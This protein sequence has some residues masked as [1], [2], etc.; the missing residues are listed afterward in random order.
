MGIA[1]CAAIAAEAVA[2]ASGGDSYLAVIV[3]AL[4]AIV[5]GGLNTYKKGWIAL[6]NRNLN[7]NALMSIAVTGALLIGQ[8]LE[9]AMVMVLFALA[10]LIE[11]LSLD[12]ARN[13]IRGVMAMA[14]DKATVQQAEGNWAE[15]D[16]RQ[17]IVGSRIRVRPGE[18]I[19]LE[20][21]LLNGQSSVNQAPITGESI[22][23]VKTIGDPVFAGTINETGSFEYRVT[24]EATHST[25]A[26]II[27]AVEEAQG[28][29]TPT[30][31]FVDQFAKVYTPVVFELA[32]LVAVV[33]PLMLGQ[34]WLDWIYKALVLL[35][36][37][38]PC[39]LVIPPP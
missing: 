34:A 1:G 12:R 19:P 24:A 4:I 29:R 26:R 28:S 36:I 17:V 21:E 13:A 9:A 32:L 25:I 20:G 23:V 35:V 10:E 16:A 11:S 18:R 7:N 38:C 8:W 2:F 3:L 27:H 30:Q 15:M 39:A 6:R 31:R 14:P 22:P 37:A 5:A 33:P